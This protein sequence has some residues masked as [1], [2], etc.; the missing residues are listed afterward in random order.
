MCRD[1][2]EP[3]PNRPAQSTRPLVNSSTGWRLPAW[4]QG[5][6]AVGREIQ[7]RGRPPDGPDPRKE[8]PS[9]AQ[10]AGPSPDWTQIQCRSFSKARL[11]F[12]HQIH[13][14]LSIERL[15]ESATKITYPSIVFTT[16]AARG[17]V[18]GQSRWE[19]HKSVM[20]IKF[21]NMYQ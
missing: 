11:V 12:S 6:V 16:K 5:P 13:H 4:W 1:A 20:Y 3:R 9:Q 18:L 10:H 19:C 15:A 14:E 21:I 17:R 2:R 7:G 8:E